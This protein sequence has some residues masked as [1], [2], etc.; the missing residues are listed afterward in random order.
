MDLPVVNTESLKQLVIGM[1]PL[2]NHLITDSDFAKGI[3]ATSKDSQM[4]SNRKFGLLLL[5]CLVVKKITFSDVSIRKLWF[6]DDNNILS[7]IFELLSK[8]MCMY[9]AYEK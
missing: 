7:S 1:D 2:L 6:S 4:D 8:C 3:F 5:S 9:I